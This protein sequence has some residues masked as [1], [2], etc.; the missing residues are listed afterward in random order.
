[1]KFLSLK[2]PS[3]SKIKKIK[4]PRETEYTCI[5]KFDQ[6]KPKSTKNDQCLLSYDNNSY[7][8]YIHSRS[9]ITFRK[10]NINITT[11][12]IHI[13]KKREKNLYRLKNIT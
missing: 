3:R 13:K 10:Y 1:M 6:I 11:H 8:G 7:T 12:L 5:S 2:F 4:T 9:P